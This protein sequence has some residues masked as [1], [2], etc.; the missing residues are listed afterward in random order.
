[1]TKKKKT[2]AGVSG[3]AGSDDIDFLTIKYPQYYNGY[4]IRVEFNI[5]DHIDHYS[6]HDAPDSVSIELTIEDL[7][8]IQKQIR[9][10]IKDANRYRDEQFPKRPR[11]VSG[12]E[13]R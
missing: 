2:E 7:G 6:Y 4:F 1:M 11:R 10:A 5:A 13:E 8:I 12:Q 9:R 3:V